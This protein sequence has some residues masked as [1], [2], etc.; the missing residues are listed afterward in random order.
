MFDLFFKKMYIYASI[1]KKR[2]P[3]T[4]VETFT[5]LILGD[6]GRSFYTD[7]PWLVIKASTQNLH[8][9]PFTHGG[10]S[11]YLSFKTGE[12]DFPE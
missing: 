11:T 9:A 12:F 10:P 1:R 5:A 4:P 3:P 7:T 2:L 8:A 6:T